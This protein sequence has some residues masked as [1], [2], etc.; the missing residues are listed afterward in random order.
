MGMKRVKIK[1]A[2][3]TLGIFV[4]AGGCQSKESIKLP[5]ELAGVWKTSAPKYR[6]CTFELNDR[7]IIFRNGNHLENIDV[8]FV[9]KIERVHK[10]DGT[11]YKIC[12][13]DLDGQDFKFSFYFESSTTGTIR[14]KNQK[15]IAWKKMTSVGSPLAT[16]S[17]YQPE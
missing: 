4:L 16:D 17:F 7:F 10:D 14:L 6:N 11:L 2:I 13:E 3:L 5:S 12:Y 9:S 8:N 1:S 15:K